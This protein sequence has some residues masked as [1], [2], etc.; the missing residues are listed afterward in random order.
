MIPEPG[1]PVPR[2][3]ETRIAWTT[4][5]PALVAVTVGGV[6]LASAAILGTDAASRL[7]VGLA[8]V[9]L[10]A[11]AG[12]GF[13]QR[14]RLS[15]LPGAEPRL[16]VRTLTGPDEYARDQILRARVISYRRLGRKVP[17]LELDV[18]HADAER[19]LIFGRWDLG[20]NPE[21]VYRDLV[22]ALRLSEDKTS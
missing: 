9:G 4:P 17:M 16:V 12:L 1:G 5:T 11:L 6:I 15:V 22:A 14:P 20:V 18:Q 10:L 2:D 3:A 7:L 8:A 21:F 19:L 13:R